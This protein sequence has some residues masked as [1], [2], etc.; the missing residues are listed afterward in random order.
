MLVLCYLLFSI[1]H[2]VYRNQ[3]HTHLHFISFGI[4]VSRVF[5][6][7]LICSFI[8]ARST[9]RREAKIDGN[10]SQQK[11][12]DNTY[13][14]RL[15]RLKEELNGPTVTE[16]IQMHKHMWEEARGTP[17]QQTDSVENAS[18]QSA[19]NLTSKPTPNI[20]TITNSNMMQPLNAAQSFDRDK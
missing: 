17:N 16:I 7:S 13:E 12:V 14:A 8:H 9:K 6:H 1:I 3:F 5:I 20:D 2:P 18:K 10:S 19:K 15:K 4:S 11:L